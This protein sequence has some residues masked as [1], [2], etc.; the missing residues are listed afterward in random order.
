MSLTPRSVFG[1]LFRPSAIPIRVR[2]TLWYVALLAA[3]LI[4]FSGFLYLSFSRSLR[5]SRM[6]A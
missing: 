5:R 3:I 6:P 2:L 4:T 1:I